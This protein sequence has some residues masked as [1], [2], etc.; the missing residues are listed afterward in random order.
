MRHRCVCCACA[1]LCCAVQL[2][3]SAYHAVC[4][5]ACAHCT[6]GDAFEPGTL[7]TTCSSNTQPS[8][9]NHS[10]AQHSTAHGEPADRMNGTMTPPSV[11]EPHRSCSAAMRVSHLSNCRSVTRAGAASEGC[12]R[13]DGWASQ[14]ELRTTN[15][16]G[17]GGQR[18]ECGSGGT[19]VRMA[20]GGSGPH[21]QR[22][23]RERR[24]DDSRDAQRR[25]RGWAAQHGLGAIRPV[26]L[27]G[28]YAKINHWEGGTTARA[29]TPIMLI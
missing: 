17:C 23:R 19:V 16:D 9:A 3:V 24:N 7:R 26:H 13:T 27:A 1:V 11:G 5:S 14:W 10:T 4:R 25:R 29:T 18:A 20:G 8:R 6:H 12:G 21:E 2:R 15:G 22:V 28:G